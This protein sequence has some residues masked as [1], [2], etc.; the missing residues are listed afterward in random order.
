MPDN[1][2]T[3]LAGTIVTL[4]RNHCGLFWRIMMPV[5]IVA[6]SLNV[7]MFFYSVTRLEKDINDAFNKDVTKT[8]CNVNTFSGIHPTVTNAAEGVKPSSNV[9]WRLYPVP[10]FSSTDE[11]GVTWRWE[12]NFLTLDY[13][14][15]ILLMLTLCPLSL[16]VANISRGSKVPDVTQNPTSLTARKM[17]HQ[18]GCKAFK[19]LV[20]FLLFVL[21]LDVISYLYGLVSWLFPSLIRALPMELPF[22]LIM[23][24]QAYVLVT[25]SLYNPC[26]I[27]EDNS[28]IAIFRRSHALVNGASLRFLGI[29]LLTGWIASV[30]TSVLLGAALLVFS[31]FIPDLVLVR[32]ALSS[33]AFL[34]LFIGVD[35]EV[36]LPQLLS[37]PVTVV[38]LIVKGLI[39]TFLV[40]IWAILTTLLYLERMD[41]QPDI[42][43]GAV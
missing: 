4:Y 38:I 32:D 5:A 10:Y 6:I 18:T 2:G 29:Y 13:G 21:I 42:I 33:F 41:V 9:A 17:W 8:T 26:L 12:P 1:Q 15:L 22:I 24:Y 28:I 36:V 40:P 35:V 14:L 7:G 34:T 31:L 20:A 3:K 19:V 30:I 27:L 37:V 25:L 43:E 11:K 39:A 16:A 23:V